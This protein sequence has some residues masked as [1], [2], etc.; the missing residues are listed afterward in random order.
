MTKKIIITSGIILILIGLFFLFSQKNNPS[1]KNNS[2]EDIISDIIEPTK[3]INY[4]D[5]GIN[6][7]DYE[8]FT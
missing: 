5:L 3:T 1:T 6:P 4:D 7:N 8:S 2:K